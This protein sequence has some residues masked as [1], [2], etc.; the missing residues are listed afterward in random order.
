MSPS[1]RKTSLRVT[2][3][4][5]AF[6]F[7]YGL[8]TWMRPSIEE[9]TIQAAHAWNAGEIRQAEKFARSALA[10]SGDTSGARDVLIQVAAHDANPMLHVAVLLSV[11][12]DSSTGPQLRYEAGELAFQA[13]YA[14]VAEKCWKDAQRLLPGFAAAHDRLIMLAGVRL[15]PA[16]VSTALVEKTKTFPLQIASLRLL[17][18]A[19]SIALEAASMEESLQRFVHKDPSD[20]ASRIALARCLIELGRPAEAEQLLEEGEQ[21]P[22]V[23]LLLAQTRFRLGQPDPFTTLP[24]SPLVGFAGDYWLLRGIEASR[25][26]HT[27]YAVDCLEKAVSQRPLDRKIRSQYCEVLRLAGD[28]EENQ[29]Q[30]D[31]LR[32]LQELEQT[33][34]NPSTIWDVNTVSQLAEQCRE[35]GAESVAELLSKYVNSL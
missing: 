14:A 9:L 7:G 32:V 8:Q 6:A 24:D 16:S 20:H 13:G 15:D 18:G 1:T 3:A 31:Q 2:G 5:I 33:A 26:N 19:E 10:R 28:V 35:V 29:K 23:Q 17:V 27:E 25:S 4:I 11:P 21:I 34:K 12:E 30:S 22:S